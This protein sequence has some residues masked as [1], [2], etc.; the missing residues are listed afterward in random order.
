M[1]KYLLEFNYAEWMNIP[2]KTETVEW[3]CG[4]SSYIMPLPCGGFIRATKI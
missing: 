1:N 4:K 3:N 2:Y